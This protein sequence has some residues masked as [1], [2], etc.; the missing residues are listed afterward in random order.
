MRTAVERLLTPIKTV[1][2]SGFNSI[3]STGAPNVAGGL[4]ESVKI[5]PCACTNDY[6]IACQIDGPRFPTNFAGKAFR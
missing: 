6:G 3:G 4:V 2:P 1:S 5:C